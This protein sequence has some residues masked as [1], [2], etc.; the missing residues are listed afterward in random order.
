MAR[1]IN[2]KLL[3]DFFNKIGQKETLPAER[4]DRATD[5]KSAMTGQKKDGRN[6]LRQT[7]PGESRQNAFLVVGKFEG[8]HSAGKLQVQCWINC[9]HSFDVLS[10][11]LVSSCGRLGGCAQQE[12]DQMPRIELQ[13]I[14]GLSDRLLRPSGQEVS[15]CA[16]WKPEKHTG[17]V[18]TEAPRAFEHIERAV[19]L[20][21]Q[22]I[23]EA[24]AAANPY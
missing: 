11:R 15:D 22:G 7:C 24:V 5:L 18:R 19:G 9:A 16:A 1:L 17:I 20:T 21:A 14:L 8:Q 6:L 3:A 23:P 4:P 2:L 12:R 13:C 10:G